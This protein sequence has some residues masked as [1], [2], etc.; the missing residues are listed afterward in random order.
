MA[1]R[2]RRL[3]L[4]TVAFGAGAYLTTWL[5]TRDGNLKVKYSL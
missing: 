5:L 4:G 3:A 1:S 2:L